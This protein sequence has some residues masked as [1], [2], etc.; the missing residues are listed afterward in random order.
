MSAKLQRWI[1][2]DYAEAARDDAVS[3]VA[4]VGQ[5][6]GALYG[7]VYSG[8]RNK[9]D[10]HYRFRKPEE[11]AKQISD[12]LTRLRASQE[13]KAEWKAKRKASGRGLE[14]GDVVRTCWGYDQTNVEYFQVTALIGAT[15]VELREIAQ[16]GEETGFMCGQCV[17][18][19]NEFIGEPIRRVAKDGRVKIDDVRSGH[20]VEPT[21]TPAG[22]IY[23]SAYWSSY[24]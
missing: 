24:A 9:P 2:K 22:P 15:M 11:C 21:E 14:V 20:K 17:P 23:P 12:W 18:M 7:I 10:W 6:A 19:R 16:E 8:K 4:Y 13:L 5:K 1:P 3:A